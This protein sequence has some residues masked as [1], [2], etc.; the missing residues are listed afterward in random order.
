MD[1]NAIRQVLLDV[2]DE[3]APGC[4]P[5]EID[6]D[7]DIREQMDLDSM[8]LLNVVAGLHERLG[9]VVPEADIEQITTIT[10][11]VDYLTSHH[12]GAAS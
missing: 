6:D 10:G 7:E 8:D 2:I 11:A 3:V 12:A 4:L 1:K 9:V 5:D